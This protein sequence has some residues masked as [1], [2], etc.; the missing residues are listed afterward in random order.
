[1]CEFRFSETPSSSKTVKQQVFQ[2]AHTTTVK[3][4]PNFRL[5]ILFKTKPESINSP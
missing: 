3:E 1:M 4:L 5:L 2:V